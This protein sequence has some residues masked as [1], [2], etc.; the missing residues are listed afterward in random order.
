M[1]RLV[2]LAICGFVGVLAVVRFLED[3][4]KLSERDQD[5]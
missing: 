2:V 1:V 4:D 5:L 3:L